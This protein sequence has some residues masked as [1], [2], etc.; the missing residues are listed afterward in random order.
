MLG[1]AQIRGRICSRKQKHQFY[2]KEKEK[3]KNSTNGLVC[4]GSYCHARAMVS[5][6][7]CTHLNEFSGSGLWI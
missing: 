7:S 1:L 3:L 5:L 2:K 4:N 6:A